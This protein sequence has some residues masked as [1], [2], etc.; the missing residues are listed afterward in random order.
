MLL[1]YA[2]EVSTALAPLQGQDPRSDHMAVDTQVA[3][4]SI[5][6][7]IDGPFPGSLD[8]PGS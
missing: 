8:P 1:I 7:G 4:L 6:S 5:T 2:V 3:E